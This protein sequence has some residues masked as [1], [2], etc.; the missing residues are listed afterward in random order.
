MQGASLLGSWQVTPQTGARKVLHS[1]LDVR[2]SPGTGGTAKGVLVTPFSGL[3]E[4]QHDMRVL[5][6]CG[7]EA[8][9][10]G[11]SI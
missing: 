5:S 6:A 11:P 1:K 7:P 8:D 3:L 10:L 9:A 2:T 4:K